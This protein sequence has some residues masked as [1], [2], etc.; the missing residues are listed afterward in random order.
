MKTVWNCYEVAVW[1]IEDLL[2][3][4]GLQLT[5]NQADSRKKV[6]AAEMRSSEQALQLGSHVTAQQTPTTTVSVISEAR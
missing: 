6:V 1:E 3:E 4:P 5:S 2:Q